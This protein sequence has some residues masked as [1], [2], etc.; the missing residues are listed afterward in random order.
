[1]SQSTRVTARPVAPALAVRPDAV[2]V[3]VRIV[4][5]L[6]LDDAG[7][8]F[9]VEASKPATSVATMA[10]TR[11]LAEGVEGTLAQLL[12]Q[13]AMERGHLHVEVG[14]ALRNPVGVT[15]GFQKTTTRP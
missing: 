5:R 4:G 3:A 12:R 9:H 2:Q 13:V 11:A 8:A 14:D 15:L 7:H 6:V 10:S 1:M